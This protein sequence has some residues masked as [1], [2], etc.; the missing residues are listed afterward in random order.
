MGQG[1]YPCSFMA[2]FGTYPDHLKLS[3]AQT[4]WIAFVNFS[5]RCLILLK[6]KDP[7]P[8]TLMHWSKYVLFFLKL[9][10]IK[11]SLRGCVN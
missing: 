2:I 7:H 10:K 4:D 6:W 5:A 11:Y 3:K 9:E 1:I 8:S